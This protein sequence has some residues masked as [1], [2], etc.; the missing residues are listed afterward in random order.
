MGQVAKLCGA[1]QGQGARRVED[2][3]VIARAVHLREGDAHC[4]QE[5]RNP[6]A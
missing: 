4:G 2:N 3:E 1:R 6:M 5:Y